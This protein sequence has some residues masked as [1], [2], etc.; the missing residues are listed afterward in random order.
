MCVCA[1]KFML[2]LLSVYSKT[3]LLQQCSQCRSFQLQ[4]FGKVVI[5]KDR[6][7]YGPSTC[8]SLTANCQH[9]GGTHQ[10]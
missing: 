4:N 9:C 5:D 10:V 3:A 1:K 6:K 8:H 2:V 7:K